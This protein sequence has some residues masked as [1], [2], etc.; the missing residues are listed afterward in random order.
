MEYEEAVK[1]LGFNLT[2]TKKLRKTYNDV[3]EILEDYNFD[4]NRK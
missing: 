4:R 2:E 3:C 1:V